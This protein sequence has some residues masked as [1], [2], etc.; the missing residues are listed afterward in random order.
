MRLKLV[1][2]FENDFDVSSKEELTNVDLSILEKELYNEIFNNGGISLD[3][4]K[5]IP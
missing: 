5:E 4:L 2:E 3:D 1:Y